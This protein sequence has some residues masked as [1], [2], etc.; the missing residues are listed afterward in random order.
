MDAGDQASQR[1]FITAPG[2]SQ[3][4]RYGHTA[5]SGACFFAMC[6]PLDMDDRLRAARSEHHPEP[7]TVIL[8]GSGCVFLRHQL[9]KG[10]PVIKDT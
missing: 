6:A 2:I 8:F 4:M 9:I 1:G 3:H 5:T 7:R 10:G